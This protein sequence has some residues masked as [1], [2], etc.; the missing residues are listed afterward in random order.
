[1]PIIAHGTCEAH[2]VRHHINVDMSSLSV[3]ADRLLTLPSVC[4][5]HLAVDLGWVVVGVWE[6][7]AGGRSILRVLKSVRIGYGIKGGHIYAFIFRN[8]M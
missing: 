6:G 1:M 5:C 4:V 7:G 2:G 8:I 3:P